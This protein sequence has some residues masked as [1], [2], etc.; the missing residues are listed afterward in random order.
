VVVLKESDHF[1]ARLETL[2]EQAPDEEGEFPL[3]VVDDED[4]LLVEEGAIF[5]WSIGTLDTPSGRIRASQLR[6]ARYPAW[7]PQDVAAAKGRATSIMK[8]LDWSDQ[9]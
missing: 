3:D 5:Y 9:E 8:D 1:V 7:T 6:F 2:S 4:L